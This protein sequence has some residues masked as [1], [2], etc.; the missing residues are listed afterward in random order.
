[1]KEFSVEINE[2]KVA[3]I[4]FEDDCYIATYNVIG[5][6][7][8]VEG[9]SLNSRPVILD[10]G[11][12]IG[13]FA[14]WSLKRWNPKQVYCYEPLRKNFL[15]LQRNIE[16][17][18]QISTEFILINK[19]VEAPFTQLHAN[20]QGT[21]SS[22]FYKFYGYLEEF[23]EV[24]TMEAKDL[25]N[26]NILK[27]DTE[28]CE[29]AIVTNYLANHPKPVLFL[30]EY[31]RERDRVELDKLLYPLNYTLCYGK[32]YGPGF[33]TAFYLDCDTTVMSEEVLLRVR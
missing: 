25:P 5:N 11:A 18:P 21:A 15:Q 2:G 8:E 16:A 24:E 9:V 1:M 13:A 10:I 6:E 27:V 14:I 31:H 17:L 7:Y 19:A 3:T 20:V 32:Y 12:N 22:S 4:H 28:G 29:L 30:V 33:G 26:C 23:E